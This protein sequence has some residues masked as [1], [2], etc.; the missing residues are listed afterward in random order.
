[1]LLLRFEAHEGSRFAVS[2]P[3]KCQPVRQS[4]RLVE[5]C[6]TA[7]MTAEA[8]ASCA[9]Q[10]QTDACVQVAEQAFVSQAPARRPPKWTPAAKASSTRRHAAPLN[11]QRRPSQWGEHEAYYL[12][13]ETCG[14][15]SY[16]ANECGGALA[17]LPLFA[18]DGKN[19]KGSGEATCT[20]KQTPRRK[21]APGVLV[22]ARS[23]HLALWR[24]FQRNRIAACS[25]LAL[26]GLTQP[27]FDVTFMRPCAMDW[28]EF[29]HVVSFAATELRQLQAHC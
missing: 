9:S 25:D 23:A 17:R 3:S 24:A 20:K 19:S 2:M 12:M 11:L 4:Q 5:F 15:Q 1:M 29:L 28:R 26:H 14:Q 16:T 8:I 27:S 10:P 7:H 21:L 18:Q 13:G 22:C 6:F